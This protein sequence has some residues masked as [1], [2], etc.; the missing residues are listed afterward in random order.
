MRLVTTLL[1][2]TWGSDDEKL[3]FLGEWCKSYHSNS[4]KSRSS[5]TLVFHWEDRSKLKNNHE[6]LKNLY[7]DILCSLSDNLNEYHGVDYPLRFWRI[8]IGPW[9]LTYISVIWD[10]WESIRLAVEKYNIK[11]TIA[12]CTKNKY[13]I[14][15]DF[16]DVNSMYQDNYWNHY[17][18]LN[19]IKN[20]YP[21]INIQQIDGAIN[22]TNRLFS[23]NQKKIWKHTLSMILDKLISYFPQKHTVFIYK[24]YFP[25][26]SLIRLFLK[27]HQIPRLFGELDQNITY[28]LPDNSLRNEN[29]LNLQ[30]QNDFE[31]YISSNIL[32]DIPVSYL[33]GFKLLFDLAEKVKYEP[34]VIFTA[35]AHYASDGE[36]FRVWAGLKCAI[37]NTVLVISDHGG[38]F[39]EIMNNFS[40]EDVIA[41]IRT[42]WHIPYNDKQIQMSPQKVIG[43]GLKR[44]LGEYLSLI[45][46]E[47]SF[48]S[49]RCQTGPISSLIL[50]DYEQNKMFV[51]SLPDFIFNFMKIRPYPNLGWNTKSRYIDDFGADKVDN[52][53]DIFDTFAQAKII[54]CTYPQ[55]TFFQAMYS[56]HPTILLYNDKYWKSYSVFDALTSELFE[57]LIIF[58]CPK[59][60]AK[61]INDIWENPLE[62]WDNPK[63]LLARNNFNYV[64]GSVDDNPIDQWASFFKVYTTDVV[65]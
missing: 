32:K 65:N 9:L 63:T 28:P 38:A 56:G 13:S 45:G 6:Y 34:K 44:E 19:I 5:E 26:K 3:L 61:H 49:F 52:S 33:E 39:R 15:N 23:R 8:L 42:V 62:W 18:Y 14:P 51:Q 24:G 48:Y 37:G 58:R 31:E 53:S 30:V 60:A 55:T 10:R 16:I 36:L 43:K 27:L 21:S 64:C 22:Q 20:Q 7:E 11:S 2:E 47:I 40:H 1:E 35:N 41:D 50:K 46:L 59:K 29:S 57:A 54:V 4:W 25:I 17:L 12:L